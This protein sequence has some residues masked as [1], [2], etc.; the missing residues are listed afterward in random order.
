MELNFDDVT[1]DQPIG[2]SNPPSPAGSRV[3]RNALRRGRLG[4]RGIRE[5][6]PMHRFVELD[7]QG[8]VPQR[9]RCTVRTHSAPA[10]ERH[11]DDARFFDVPAAVREGRRTEVLELDPSVVIEDDTRAGCVCRK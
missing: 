3:L 1:L 11:P 7:R 2:G 4:V 10:I 8:P 6:G 9:S 5:V